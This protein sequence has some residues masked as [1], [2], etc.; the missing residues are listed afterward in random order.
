MN[1]DRSDNRHTNLVWATMHQQRGNQQVYDLNAHPEHRLSHRVR[2]TRIAD[3]SC[4][5]EY[6]SLSDAIRDFGLYVN[7]KAKSI[8]MKRGW[9]LETVPDK[10]L[11]GEVW[12]PHCSGFCFSNLGR[13]SIDKLTKRYAP[14]NA[15]GYPQVQRKGKNLLVHIGVLEAFGFAKPSDIHTVDHINRCK[16]DNRLE[17]LRWASPHTQRS[18]QVRSPMQSKTFSGRKIGTREWITYSRTRDAADA[19]GCDAQRITQ[20]LNPKQRMQTTP[21]KDGRYEFRLEH[22]PSQDD[23]EDE[24]WKPFVDADWLPG[25]RYHCVRS[26]VRD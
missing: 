14:L 2:L 18:N 17:N 11:E 4:V 23:I 20:V 15:H 25:G 22:D 8:I 19:T 12:R 16:T 1:R 5:H 13:S 6:D 3:S 21:G 10:D 9:T 7:G 26:N 24:E